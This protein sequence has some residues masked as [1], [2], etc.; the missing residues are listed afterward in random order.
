MTREVDPA[1]GSVAACAADAS[2]P[3]PGERAASVFANPP[4]TAEKT[5][6]AETPPELPEAVA[7]PATDDSEPVG[8]VQSWVRSAPSWLASL[9]IHLALLLLLAITVSVATHDADQ[10]APLEAV[11]AD[12]LGEQLLD[13]TGPFQDEPTTATET[14]ITAPAPI[15]VDDPFS[16]PPP[17]D[18]AL[19][20]QGVASNVSAPIAG[21]LF[22]GREE[23]MKRSLLQAYGGTA[24]TEGAVTRGLAWLARQQRPDGT[25]SLK[26]PYGEGGSIE[27]VPAATAMALLA[28]L[29]NGNTHARGKYK[30]NVAK[31]MESLLRLQDRQGC[32]YPADEASNGRFYT[33]GQ[34]TIALCELYAM[35]ND[36]S[37]EEPATRAVK[38]LLE[39][40]DRSKGGWRYLPN[41]DSDTSVTGWALMGLQS[42]RQGGIEVPK[43]TLQRISGYLDSVANDNGATYAYQQGFPPTPSMTAEGLLCRQFLGWD[44]YDPRLEQGVRLL[45]QKEN[46]PTWEERKRD[47]YYWYY[48]T[49]VMHHMGGDFWRTWN[50]AMKA[51]LVEHQ[52]TSG[53]DAGSWHP[54]LPVEDRWGFHGGRLYVTCLSI[55]MLE[56]Y[57]RHM[58]LYADAA[59]APKPAE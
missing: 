43:E 20:P 52:V 1:A 57:Y 9:V 13:D 22:A 47:A 18:L 50:D 37:L 2:L 55:Y 44:H 15:A 54:R 21:T 26:G 29:G 41:E 24:L 31:G 7:E 17:S 4:S 27:N 11:F 45:L 40:Q 12:Q 8:W 59:S 49:Q 56:V 35:T 28:F 3:A 10:E 6:P 46:L 14:V 16:A 39:S 5:V 42:A 58:P 48:A 53:K 19:S 33:Q 51:T 25:W 23:G 32:F 34:C 30:E 38:Y 36:T